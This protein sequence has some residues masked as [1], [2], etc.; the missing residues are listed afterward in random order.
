MRWRIED[1]ARLARVAIFVSRYHHCL[2]DLLHRRQA[3]ELR[4]E[5]VL[6]VSNHLDAQPLAEFYQVPF[7]HVPVDIA[8]KSREAEAQAES[9]PSNGTRST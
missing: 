1:T 8:N 9:T 5:V 4:C 2:L 6:V 7:Y 3:G